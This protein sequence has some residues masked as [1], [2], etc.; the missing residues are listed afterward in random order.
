MAYQRILRGAPATITV[1]F[2]DQHGEARSVSGVTVDVQRADGS[3]LL[4]EVNL[5]SNS[6]TLEVPIELTSMQTADLDIL[7]VIATVPA[8]GSI[9]TSKV[10]IVGGVLFTLAEAR[11]QEPSLATKTDEQLRNIRSRV[12]SEAERA[13]NRAFAY[14]LCRYDVQRRDLATYTRR[15]AGFKLQRP[16]TVGGLTFANPEA[17]GP[18]L[19]VNGPTLAVDTSIPIYVEAGMD[20]IP[21]FFVAAAIARMKDIVAGGSASYDPRA[22]SQSTDVGTFTLVTAGVRGARTS[23][24]EWNAALEDLCW[25]TT[26]VMSVP[27]R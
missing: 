26:S 13:C 25:D 27:I 23:S 14:R 15:I 1:T 17:I 8:D 4:H 24:P 18:V 2:A 3:L 6:E 5:Q 19:T 16:V 22:T 11:A 21:E 20:H 7:Y 9:A 12:E 10:D